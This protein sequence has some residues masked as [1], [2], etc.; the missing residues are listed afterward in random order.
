MVK[1]IILCSESLRQ[2]N[3]KA[4]VSE[5]YSIDARAVI[6]LLKNNIESLRAGKVEIEP[7]GFNGKDSFMKKVPILVQDT[8]EAFRHR[9]EELEM[10]FIALRDA[11]TNDNRKITAIRR[12]L[13]DQIRNRITEQESDRVHV[14]FAVQ[15]IEA[16]ML[17]DA[18]RLNEYLGITSKAKHFND[19]EAIENPKQLVISLFELV[20][21]KYTPQELLLLLPQLGIA[22]ISR[23]KHFKKLYDCVS[24]IAGG[25]A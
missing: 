8:F 21:K 19:P 3:G 14:M 12:R 9:S 5:Q 1:R 16:W 15:A 13:V 10:F 11:D 18:Q 25:S 2:V 6:E 4:K 23:C 7:R 17:S 24:K 22:E 20:R